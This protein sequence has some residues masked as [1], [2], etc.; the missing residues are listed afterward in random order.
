[1]KYFIQN[2]EIDNQIKEIRKKVRLSMNGVVADTMKERGL[3]YKQ[4]F[5]VQ[6]P[7]LKEIASAYT[8]NYDLAQRLWALNIRETM[9]LATLLQPIENFTEK[10]A[11]DWLDNIQNIELA[12]Q[13]CMNLFAKLPFAKEWSIKRIYS[14][15]L[16]EQIT[17]FI[18]ATRIR[19]KFNFQD[20]NEIV[21]RAFQ[22][23][24]TEEYH[25][26]KA[27]S[28]CLARICRNSKE[29]KNFIADKIIP[30]E[31][32]E[33]KGLRYAFT[34]ITQEISFLDF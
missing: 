12:E 10:N 24:E 26:Y 14:E 15:K 3:I 16:W 27:V 23:L 20:I 18:L 7:R 29:I 6:T 31:K 11:D 5:G 30:Y 34:E 4:N 8:P 17:G 28:V 19:E 22:L 25:L 32:S 1:M 33:K 9:I 13:T 2:P 21:N